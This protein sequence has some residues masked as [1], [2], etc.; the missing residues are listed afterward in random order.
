[1]LKNR[2][3][4]TSLLKDIDKARPVE[5][6]CNIFHQL[7]M[8]PVIHNTRSDHIQLNI[9]YNCNINSFNVCAC[10]ITCWRNAEL[11]EPI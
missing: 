5:E 2:Q 9:F 6:A 3:L 10:F 4:K 8:K 1:M 11:L 7:C